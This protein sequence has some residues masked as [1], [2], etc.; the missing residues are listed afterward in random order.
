VLRRLG[1]ELD[2]IARELNVPVGTVKS[3]LSRARATLAPL[4]REDVD[5][6][7]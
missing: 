5:D 7:A 4:L 3:R 6:H 2:Q 1:L